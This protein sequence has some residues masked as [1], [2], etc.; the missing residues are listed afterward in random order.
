VPAAR[1][2]LTHLLPAATFGVPLSPVGEGE[3]IPLSL[4]GAHVPGYP[5]AT[6]FTYAFD[7]GDGEGYGVFSV[8]TSVSCPT[9]DGPAVRAVG[10]MVMDEDGDTQEYT[11]A[12]AI[13]NIAPTIESISIPTAPV[14]LSAQPVIAAATFSDPAGAADEPYTCTVDY[15][16][17]SGP[18]AGTATG[19]SC[20]GPDQTY[21]ATGVFAV[22]VHV[23]DDDGDT[24]TATSTDFIVV[25]EPANGF[26][27]GGGWIDSPAGAYLPD[28]SMAGKATFAFVSKYEK[29]QAVPE[30]NTQFRF[31]A[32]GLVFDS[33]QYDWLIVSQAGTA[34]QFRGEGLIGG[35]SAPNGEPW[36]FMVWAVDG[37]PDTFRI[38]IWWEDN[39]A[40][41]VV[42]DNGFGQPIGGGAIAV[43]AGKKK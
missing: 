25:Y 22:T 33:Y 6:A 43:H 16:D 36:R 26:V 41:I 21:S 4:T 3:A 30:G 42:Y 31:Q 10:A 24:G 38:R 17:G 15:G 9:I 40:E 35:D 28:P 8:T 29:G 39:G 23:T 18:R 14:A 32:A 7:C 12:V 37:E 1:Q 27:T 34:A 5:T 13:L 19:S 20:T 2:A 11:A